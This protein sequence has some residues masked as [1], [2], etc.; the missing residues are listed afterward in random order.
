MIFGSDKGITKYDVNFKKI[1]HIDTKDKVQCIY[2]INKI[3]SL[4]G[5]SN[6]YIQL[7]NKYLSI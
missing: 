7:M 3:S 6:G 1:S 4:I 2:N 5:Q